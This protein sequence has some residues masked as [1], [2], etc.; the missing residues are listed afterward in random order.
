M[1]NFLQQAMKFGEEQLAKQNSG[2]NQQYGGQG[3]GQNQNQG[4]GGQ[5]P[6]QNQGY[7]GQSGQG[8]PSGNEDN[9]GQ[10]GGTGGGYGGQGLGQ[11]GYDGQNN[12]GNNQSG[13]DFGITGGAQFNRPHGQGG[14]GGPPSVGIDHSAALQAAGAGS[15]G[16]HQ[17]E[18]SLFS[19][20][21]SYIQ[22]MG[23]NP[24]AA[25]DLDEDDV[26]RKHEQAYG[27]GNAGGMSANALGAAAAMQAMKKFTSGSG[28]GAPASG[29]GGDMQSNLIGMAMKEAAK[30]FDQSGGAAS[31]TKQDAVSGAGATIMKLLMKQQMAGMMGGQ[32]SGG[33]SQLMGMASKF[34]K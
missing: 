9:Y 14:A 15:G 3:Q 11:G 16:N 28:G 19:S 2:G 27:Q 10:T 5:A 26:Q 23:G 12:Y 25:E 20:A 31:G 7:G 32:N 24:S 29:Q 30:L 18:S 17:G 34:M 6:N 33:L 22:G 8:Y 13:G 4:Y 1:N 21:L